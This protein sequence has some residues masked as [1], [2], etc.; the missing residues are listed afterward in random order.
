[1]PTFPTVTDLNVT[2]ATSRRASLPLQRSESTSSSESPKPPKLAGIYN[3][4]S[5]LQ[6]ASSSASSSPSC[7]N[8]NNPNVANANVE[9]ASTSGISAITPQKVIQSN[10]SQLCAVCGD[11][12][13]CQHYGVRTC[14]GCKGF[15]KRTVQKGAKY[16]CLADKAC[17][18]DKRR[19][20]RCQFC[21]FQV[22]VISWKNEDENVRE[23]LN[24]FVKQ[25]ASKK[26]NRVS[27]RYQAFQ[28]STLFHLGRDFIVIKDFC[29]DNA[30]FSELFCFFISN[31]F[32]SLPT[33]MFG[34]WYG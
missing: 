2:S 3:K 13:A 33:E 19:R 7:I 20:N 29:E 11:I 23:T 16:V 14:E 4:Y 18:V 21:R 22:S 6:S 31:V 15:F 26:S 27:R 12:A 34:C 25:S 9:M 1:L 32:V 10:P 30:K 24:I 17:P 28:N 5:V 8:N